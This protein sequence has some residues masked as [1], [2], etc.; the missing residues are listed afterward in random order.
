MDKRYRLVYGETHNSVHIKDDIKNEK[1]KNFPVDLLNEYELKQQL[2]LDKLHELGY[3]LVYY[4]PKDK[5]YD[6]EWVIDKIDNIQS[7]LV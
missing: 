5:D 2:L 3:D 4:E 6:G 7:R 1:V